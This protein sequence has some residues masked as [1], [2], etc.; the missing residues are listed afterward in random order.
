[1]SLMGR[2]LL[3]L[4]VGVAMSGCTQTVW[5]KS[6]LTEA[7]YRTDSYACERDMRQSGYFGTGLAGAL[8]ARDFQERCMLSK[9]YRKATEDEL[10]RSGTQIWR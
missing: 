10:N 9:G 6:G 3:L 4:V 5:T 2:L 8:N 7:E 1:M